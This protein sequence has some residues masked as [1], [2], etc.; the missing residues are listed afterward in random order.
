[1]QIFAMVRLGVVAMALG[2]AG[3]ALSSCGFQPIYAEKTQVNADFGAVRVATGEGR[4]AYLVRQAVIDT[5][6]AERPGVEPQYNLLIGIRESRTG[7][8]LRVND[9]ATRFEITLAGSY[10]LVDRRTGKTVRQGDIQASASFDVTD[11]VYA[12]IAVEENAKERAADLLAERVERDLSLFFLDRHKARAAGDAGSGS[13][14][15]GQDTS[16]SGVEVLPGDS[17]VDVAPVDGAGDGVDRLP[18]AP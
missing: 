15:T 6:G 2:G 9:V 13:G 4:A 3:L 5:L 1:M 7:F 17:V 16:L 11:D 18:P 10:R 14:S 8:G 12:D